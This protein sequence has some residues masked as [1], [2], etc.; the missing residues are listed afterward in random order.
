MR[1]FLIRRLISMFIS[2]VGA[3]FI[4]FVLS[5]LGP[6]PLAILMGEVS[7]AVTQEDIDRYRAQLGLDKTLPEQ[8]GIWLWNLAHFDFGQSTQGWSISGRIRDHMGTTLKLAAGAWTIAIVVGVSMGV[9]SAVKRA[10]FWDYVA[11]GFALF[12]LAI[13]TFWAGIMAILI[14]AVILGWLPA[15][16]LGDQEGF[17]LAWHNLRH[18]IMPWIVLGWP[19]SAG[20]MRLTR[21]S[22][23]EVLD[24]EYIKLARAKGARNMTVI[25]KHALRNA[26]IPPLTAA[27]LLLS[28][29]MSGALIVEVIFSLPGIAQLAVGSIYGNDLPFL[30]AT[31]LVFVVIYLGFA[32]IADILYAIVDPRIRYS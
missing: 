17:P 27:L 12:G 8:Y 32:F 26:I 28:G 29:Y 4:I 21:S 24:S 10:T 5:K 2:I 13:P 11:R 6:D 15:G 3:T 30:A 20:I 19:P 9:L 22:M 23:L 25:W 31:T 16:T 14:F 1:R 7:S 18:W